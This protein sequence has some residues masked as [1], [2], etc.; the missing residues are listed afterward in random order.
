MDV[1]DRLPPVAARV[2]AVVR[3]LRPLNMV[4]FLAG[5]VVGGVLSAGTETFVGAA[6]TRLTGAAVSAALIGG[7]ANSLNDV[8]DVAVDR[9][10]RPERPLPSGQLPV[11]VAWGVWGLGSVGG[12][13]LAAWLSSAHLAMAAAAVALL[14][15][16]SVWLKR[17]PLVGNLVVAGVVALSL[18]YGGWAVGGAAA[19][20]PGAAFAF[21]TT[22]ARE[23]A[24]DIDD[25][26]GD[27]VVRSRTLPLVAG[28][29]VAGRTA[30]AVVALTVL[31]TPVPYLALSYGGLYLLVVLVADLLMLRALGLLLNAPARDAR[32]ASEVLK[33]AML[34]GLVALAL[35]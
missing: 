33:G 31:L 25:V 12:L 35:A 28:P 2:W 14:A 11:A 21:L 10:N 5:V 1:N 18:I 9:L 17:R 15:A 24:K 13:A 4:M 32:W 22:L 27:A 8:F 7:A 29:N 23:V 19:A 20:L 3:L 34:A 30:A 6:A 26:V 16:Y